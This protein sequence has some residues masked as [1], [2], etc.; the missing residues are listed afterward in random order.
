MRDGH[1]IGLHYRLEKNSYPKYRLTGLQNRHWNI[2]RQVGT[3]YAF[4]NW[5][6]DGE[7]R[8]DRIS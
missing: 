6:F 8:R 4:E 1:L 3:E 7:A 2:T 5:G